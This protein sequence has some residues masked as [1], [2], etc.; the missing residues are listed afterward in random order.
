M[1]KKLLE[2][3]NQ[4]GFSLTEMMIVLAILGV[5]LAAMYNTFTHQQKSYSVQDNVSVMQQNVR[6]G[7]DYLVKDIRMAGYIPEDI[8]FDTSDPPIPT[9]S[10]TEPSTDVAGQLFTDGVAES[11]EQATSTSITFQADID[12][13]A[14]TET[15][16]YTLNGTNLTMEVW[17]WNPVTLSWNPSS[18]PQIVAEDIESLTFTYS[19][20]ADNYGLDNDVDD[21]GNDGA[22]ET[23][24]LLT[25]DLN[26]GLDDDDDGWI[27]EDGPLNT[28]QLRSLIRNVYV[29]IN[30]RSA[31]KDPKY[32]H[33]TEGDSYRRRTLT[34]NIGLRNI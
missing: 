34:S 30:S 32:T 31:V 13:D 7:L 22:D 20:L 26:N 25:W 17:Q 24:E 4:S 21:D 6:V 5:V 27:D 8:P 14:V 10:T 1:M 2:K 16:Q 33:P 19:L 18:G 9:P 29:V 15:V 28:N 11:I 12:N 23:G 3:N